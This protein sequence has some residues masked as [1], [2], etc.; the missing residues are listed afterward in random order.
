[1][2]SQV[3]SFWLDLDDEAAFDAFMADEVLQHGLEDYAVNT[4]ICNMALERDLALMKAASPM[5]FPLLERF[6]ASGF[7]SQWLREHKAAGGQDPRGTAKAKD[8]IAAGVPLARGQSNQP[9]SQPRKSRGVFTYIGANRCKRR[10]TLKERGAEFR[11]L[12][13]EFYS[14]PSVEQNIY[15]SKEQQGA[16]VRAQAGEGCDPDPEEQ[17]DIA[18]ADKLWGLS[19]R[20]Q[21]VDVSQVSNVIV[22][23]TPAG[24]GPGMHNYCENMRASFACGIIVHDHPDDGIDPAKR[25]DRHVPCGIRHPG[26]CPHKTPAI[27]DLALR[28]KG[29]IEA[30]MI[31]HNKAGSYFH[32]H[33][34]PAALQVYCRVAI[35]QKLNDTTLVSFFEVERHGDQDLELKRRPGHPLL[36]QNP[37]YAS[38][39]AVRFLMAPG[40]VT[41]LVATELEVMKLAGEGSK[42][43]LTRPVSDTEVLDNDIRVARAKKDKEVARDLAAARIDAGFRR[44]RQAVHHQGRPR[45]KRAASGSGV[46]DGPDDGPYDGGGESDESGRSSVGSRSDGDSAFSLGSGDVDG[47]DDDP[48]DGGVG[49][50]PGGSGPGGGAAVAAL[51]V[52]VAGDDPPIVPPGDGG[53]GEGGGGGGGP[54]V[55]PADPPG[56]PGGGGHGD[57][58]D[59]NRHWDVLVVRG[60][61]AREVIGKI[62][63]NA[64]ARSLDAHCYHP[65]HRD[66]HLGCHCNRTVNPTRGKGRPL[67]FLIAWLRVAHRYGGRT[68]HFQSRLG[69]GDGVDTVSFDVRRAIRLELLRGPVLGRCSSL[70]A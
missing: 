6:V 4:P 48:R 57:G 22:K 66:S 35:V 24:A 1:M 19:S 56:P 29:N 38:Q 30:L 70:R 63:W 12:A 41:S 59:G 3:Q 54:P 26:L 27:Y 15:K 47:S 13:H 64:V 49:P 9:A 42:V 61:F 46:G 68:A 40:G 51:P 5:K 20:C 34:L 11:E 60:L 32:F 55:P 16:E 25:Y 62:V 69:G 8:L 50:G 18:I 14:M 37:I 58:G 21:P 7:L 2:P 31:N 33:S 10:K 23:H 67:A 43:R 52:P 45:T 36:L 53:D 28:I 39:L 17:Y 65:M 44:L